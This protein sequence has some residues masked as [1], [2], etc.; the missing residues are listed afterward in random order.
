MIV[1]FVTAVLL[2]AS[3]IQGL[4]LN[5]PADGSTIYSGGLVTINVVALPEPGPDTG[6]TAAQIDFSGQGGSIA[7]T[8]I[9]AANFGQNI[10]FLLPS[11]FNAGSATVSAVP[12]GGTS[13]AIT[14]TNI[15]TVEAAPSP[16][17]APVVVLPVTPY[18]CY[19]PVYNNNCYNPC[20]NPVYNNNCYKP[21]RGPVC[22]IPRPIK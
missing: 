6:V 10:P 20:L 17:P 15:V 22:N 7:S 13:E 19:N 14:D 16:D 2:L 3:A 8:T 4:V 12:I 11:D 18:P 5:S 1:N 21:C 9:P